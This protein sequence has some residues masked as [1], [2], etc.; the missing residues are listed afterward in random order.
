MKDGNLSPGGRMKQLV[1][2]G[3]AVAT[4]ALIGA[5][6]QA[7]ECARPGDRDGL[8]VRALQSR[9]MVAALICDSR[10]DYNAFVTRFRPQLAEHGKRLTRYFRRAHGKRYKRELNAYV[11]ELANQASLLSNADRT[12]FCAASRNAFSRLLRAPAGDAP[13]VLSLVA[14]QTGGAADPQPGCDALSRR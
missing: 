6:A 5:S 14:A 4:A 11:T 9:L 10:S 13:R 1:K 7:M 3:G 12:G 8:S 2:F